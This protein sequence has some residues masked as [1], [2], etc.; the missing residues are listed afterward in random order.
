MFNEL[1][2][3]IVNDNILQ[4]LTNVG[5]VLAYASIT[6]QTLWALTPAHAELAT[7]LPVMESV[8]LVSYK[9]VI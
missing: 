4:M 9:Y 7:H 8:A 6:V 2:M 1:T 5:L 3:N